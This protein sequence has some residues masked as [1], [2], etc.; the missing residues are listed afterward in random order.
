MTDAKN[1]VRK[2][3]IPKITSIKILNRWI[4]EK[5]PIRKSSM[6]RGHNQLKDHFKPK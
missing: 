5:L 4:L 3:L 2:N 1:I 6:T